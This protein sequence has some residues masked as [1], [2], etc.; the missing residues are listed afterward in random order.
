MTGFDTRNLKRSINYT[1]VLRSINVSYV[2]LT[3]SIERKANM[4]LKLIN[5]IGFSIRKF[6]RSIK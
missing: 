5:I 6:K 1:I 2:Y 4:V 3:Y